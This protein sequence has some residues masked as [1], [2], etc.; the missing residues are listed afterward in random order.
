M[1]G[2]QEECLNAGMNDYISKPVRLE[3]LTGKL[4]KI[5]DP[6]SNT[7]ITPT[8]NPEDDLRKALAVLEQLKNDVYIDGRDIQFL[9][10]AAVQLSNAA[11]KEPAIYLSAFEAIKKIIAASENRQSASRK[12]ILLSEKALQKI[13][14]TPFVLPSKK[15][16]VPAL[17]LSE[18]YFQNLHKN[19]QR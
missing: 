8:A 16:S 9:R 4:E 10:L 2:D 13:A 11:A 1:Q 14:G 7:T 6:V 5:I 17:S 3:E 12:D 18:Q 15:Q 19:G